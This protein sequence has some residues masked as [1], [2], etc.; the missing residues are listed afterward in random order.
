MKKHTERVQV[1]GRLKIGWKYINH[2]EE[3]TT[4]SKIVK[5]YVYTLLVLCVLFCIA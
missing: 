2:I 1:G 4:Q 5:M 3:Y